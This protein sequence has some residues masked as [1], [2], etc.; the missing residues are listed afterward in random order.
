MNAKHIY[1]HCGNDTFIVTA[2]VTQDW[3]VN[4]R[5]EFCECLKS[6]VEVTHKPND[7]DVWECQDCGADDPIVLR[8]NE[9][10]VIISK[11]DFERF[12]KLLQQDTVDYQK[13]GIAK[14]SCI[15]S[16]T[17]QIDDLSDY[18]HEIEVDV[19]VCSSD[20]NEDVWAEAVMFDNGSEVGCSEVRDTLKDNWEFDF[21]GKT[22]V[23]VPIF[24]E[25]PYN[26]YER[27]VA[28]TVFV[29]EKEFFEMDA[30]LKQHPL[31]D[32]M[33]TRC[34]KNPVEHAHWSFEIDKSTKVI[35]FVL[36]NEAQ[37]EYWVEASAEVVK[38][39]GGVT[40]QGFAIR[41]S[42]SD[43]FSFEN[44]NGKPFNITIGAKSE[45]GNNDEEYCQHCQKMYQMEGE[46]KPCPICGRN[47]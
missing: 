17:A 37:T 31:S 4:T 6:C 30:L 1:P 27:F 35:F 11:A 40:T 5:G 9:Y 33:E 2:H 22:I 43:I 18:S 10:P 14:Y 47:T 32:D 38:E 21:D 12:E 20:W 25:T 19:K 39:F 26:D 24:A 16:W 13:E 34:Y 8:E 23:I 42:L 3:I 36:S 41:R 29:P 44:V 46:R 45:K 15:R 7:D 28:H